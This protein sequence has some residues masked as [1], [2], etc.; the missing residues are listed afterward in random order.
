MLKH[1]TVR[2]WLKAIN[3]VLIQ[4]VCQDNSSSSKSPGMIK[5]VSVVL[6]ANFLRE[7]DIIRHGRV[8]DNRVQGFLILLLLIVLINWLAV[9]IY[10]FWKL[11]LSKRFGIISLLHPINSEIDAGCIWGNF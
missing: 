3:A 7:S 6:V 8:A 11:H 5:D 2:R 1:P 9:L 10:G 4:T